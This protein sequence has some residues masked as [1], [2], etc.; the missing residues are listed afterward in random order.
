LREYI[1]TDLERKMLKDYVETGHKT[2]DTN[3]LLFRIRKSAER[4]QADMKLI[5]TVLMKEK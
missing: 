5:Q 4:L 2:K 1:L 3:V